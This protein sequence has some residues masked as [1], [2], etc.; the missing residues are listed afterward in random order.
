[1]LILFGELHIYPNKI[2]QLVSQKI[3]D[4]KQTI[5]HQNLDEVFWKLNTMDQVGGWGDKIVKFNSQE[6]CL[7]TSMPW[8]KYESMIYWYENL[9]EDP[10]FD[11][12]QYIIETGS[13]LFSSN[14][15][16]NFLLILQKITNQLNLDVTDSELEDFN[17]Y[18]HQKINIMLH[19]VNALKRP[20]LATSMPNSS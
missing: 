17:L 9:C 19:I 14:I 11:L 15:Q 18:D 1:M 5:I 4:I 6:F 16:D 2:P 12:H 20:S 13:K 8:I 3:K 10:E 7:Q